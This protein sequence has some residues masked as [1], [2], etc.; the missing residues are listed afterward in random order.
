MFIRSFIQK[1]DGI[2]HPLNAIL[3]QLTLHKWKTVY[4]SSEVFLALKL[5][6]VF[7]TVHHMLIM[8]CTEFCR[9]N[10]SSHVVLE[11]IYFLQLYS[12]R[13]L[14]KFNKFIYYLFIIRFIHTLSHSQ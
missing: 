13:L 5:I 1:A 3:P 12:F 6:H 10:F 7:F 9:L 14:F 11:K 4:M 2:L 8:V